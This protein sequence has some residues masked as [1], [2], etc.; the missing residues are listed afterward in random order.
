LYRELD[1]EQTA[2]RVELMEGWMLSDKPLSGG[3]GRKLIQTR[4]TPVRNLNDLLLHAADAVEIRH[5]GHAWCLSGTK[6]CHG[7]GVYE[8][9]NC[10]AC[11]QAVID[12]SQATTWQMIHLENLRLASITDCGPAVIQKAQ[13]AIR[14]SE[15]VLGDL[16]APLPSAEQ[17]DAYARAGTMQ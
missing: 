1:E 2:A 11:S 12:G 13:R 9:A 15:E 10:A 16:R 5:T 6:V 14:R 7:Q 4:A 17:K 8:P 3:A